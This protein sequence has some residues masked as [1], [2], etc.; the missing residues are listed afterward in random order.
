[1]RRAEAIVKGVSPSD[2]A[3]SSPVLHTR[4]RVGERLLNLTGSVASFSTPRDLTLAELRIEL[5]F[6]ADAE[7]E[8]FFAE[9]AE[10]LS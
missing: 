8:Q 9:L 7:A 3:L 2:A 1:M 6:P 10:A 4:L 5:I